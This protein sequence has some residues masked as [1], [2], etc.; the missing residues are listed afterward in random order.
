MSCLVK[1]LASSRRPNFNFN[2]ERTEANADIEK[3]LL[4]CLPITVW[5]I[6]LPGNLSPLVRLELKIPNVRENHSLEDDASFSRAPS[7]GNYFTTP[8]L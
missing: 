6:I 3:T 7:Y 8:C 4:D 5:N 1:T 2:R